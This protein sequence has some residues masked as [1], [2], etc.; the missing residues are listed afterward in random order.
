MLLF[1]FGILN[2]VSTVDYGVAV[3]IA[4]LNGLSSPSEVFQRC[5]YCVCYPLGFWISSSVDL[6]LVRCPYNWSYVVLQF[7]CYLLE[8]AY[9]LECCCGQIGRFGDPGKSPLCL[10][11]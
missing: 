2:F 6:D 1:L 10:L 9:C 3:M 5:S 7:V 8:S 4:S 11:I